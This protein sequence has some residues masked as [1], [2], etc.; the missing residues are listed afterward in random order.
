MIFYSMN[1]VIIDGE[2]SFFGA[3]RAFQY[4]LSF[5]SSYV[6]K[7]I[8]VIHTGQAGAFNKLPPPVSSV[9]VDNWAIIRNDYL[10]VLFPH[11]L[12]VIPF[13]ILLYFIYRSGQIKILAFYLANVVFVLISTFAWVGYRSLGYIWPVT[14]LTVGFGS[15]LIIEYFSNEFKGAFRNALLTC[16]VLAVSGFIFVNVILGY[17][18]AVDLNRDNDLVFNRNCVHYLLSTTSERS[19]ISYSNKTAR[20]VFWGLGLYNRHT[21]NETKKSRMNQ[22]LVDADNKFSYYVPQNRVIKLILSNTSRKNDVTLDRPNPNSLVNSNVREIRDCGDF[23]INVVKNE[24][25]K[26]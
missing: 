25:T 8:G 9:Q 24:K 21:V 16:C 13:L 12:L 6:A 10:S 22:L 11:W 23:S 5:A 26:S 15:Y 7:L 18:V 1:G 20:A 19:V 14:F 2:Y 17:V 4:Y 3:I